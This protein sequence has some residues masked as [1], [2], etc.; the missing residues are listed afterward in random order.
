MENSLYITLSRQEA[1]RRQLDVVSNNIA[2]MNTT[3]FKSQRMLFLEYMERPDKQGDRMSFVQDYG[4]LRNTEAG[5]LT[6]TNNELDVALRGEGYFAVETLSGTRYTRGGAFQLNSN[7]EVVDHSGLPLMDTNNQRI[8][9]PADAKDIHIA[10]DGSV[11]T[12][13]GPLGKLKVVTFADQQKMME[14]GGGLYEANQEE[15]AVEQPEV[16][17]GTI[18]GSNVQS[19]V[20]MTQMIDVLRTYQSVQKMIDTEHERIRGAI[21]KLARVQ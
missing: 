21:G 2:N 6:V 14:L 5:P 3:G 11:G 1:L 9:V 7:R 17:Q 16:T 4:L 20:E 12:E 19:V 18:E 13:A 10:G 8:V 15:I